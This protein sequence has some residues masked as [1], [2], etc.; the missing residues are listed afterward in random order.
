M[1]LEAQNEALAGPHVISAGPAISGQ[2]LAK[3]W[4]AAL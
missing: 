4:A 1:G 2:R 3:P